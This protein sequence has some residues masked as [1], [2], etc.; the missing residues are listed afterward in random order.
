MPYATQWLHRSPAAGRLTLTL[1]CMVLL[2]GVAHGAVKGSPEARWWKGCLHA[3]SLWSDGNVFPETAVNW[4]KSHGYNFMGLSD[5]NLLQR[6]QRWVEVT[7]DGKNKTA[8]TAAYKLYLSQFD[9]AWADERTSQGRKL[10]RLKNIEEFK[11]LFDD[12]GRFLLMPADEITFA[13]KA[14]TRLH[15]NAVGIGEGMDAGAIEPLAGACS[16]AVGQGQA[17]AR[18]IDAQG[19]AYGFPI[20]AQL[21]HPGWSHLKLEDVARIDELNHFEINNDGAGKTEELAVTERLWDEVLSRRAAQGK[22]LLYGT[23]TDDTHNYLTPDLWGPG[24]GWVMVRARY[25]TPE[26]IIKAMQAG[27]YYSSSGVELRDLNFDGRRLI[28]TIAPKWG[29]RFTTEFVGQRRGGPA[30]QVL[31]TVRGRHPAYAFKGDEIYVRARVASS[32]MVPAVKGLYPARPKLAWTQP[33]S[34]AAR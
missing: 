33:C 21:N 24:H 5:H 17:A 15:V 22:P 26:Q 18:K 32:K 9:P 14:G 16:L 29:E 19:Q 2:A 28:L 12:P 30:G 3:H 13:E 10:V 7:G 23:A 4:Y 8:S 34:P 6:G 11:P 25:L 31:S 27:D 20:F 1:A